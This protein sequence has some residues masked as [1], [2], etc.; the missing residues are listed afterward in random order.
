MRSYPRGNRAL[1]KP[2]LRRIKTEETKFFTESAGESEII[3]A[4]QPGLNPGLKNVALN[5]QLSTV[6]C[7]LSTVYYLLRFAEFC[8]RP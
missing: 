5:Y 4:N 7:Q 6:N 3:V 8:C 1:G 2:C